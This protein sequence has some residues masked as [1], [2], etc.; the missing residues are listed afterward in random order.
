MWH[1]R[2]HFQYS[3]KTGSG[4]N[5]LEEEKKKKEEENLKKKKN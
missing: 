5:Y 1:F 2:N 3:S 4:F